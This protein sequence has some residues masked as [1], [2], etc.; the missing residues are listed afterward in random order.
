[1]DTKVKKNAKINSN[2]KSNRQKMNRA[3]QSM[4]RKKMTM[5]DR[6]VAII[7]GKNYN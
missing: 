6:D 5:R 2:S 4:K 7:S 3:I 1:M